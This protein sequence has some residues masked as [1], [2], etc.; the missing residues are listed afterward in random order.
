MLRLLRVTNIVSG[1]W[2]DAHLRLADVGW[3][4]D[5]VPRADENRAPNQVDGNDAE[6]QSLVHVLRQCH[7]YFIWRTFSFCRLPA[8]SPQLYPHDTA[9]LADKC[10]WSVFHL[11]D[12]RRVWPAALHSYHDST[13]VFFSAFLRVVLRKQFNTSSVDCLR[14]RFCWSFFGHVLQSSSKLIF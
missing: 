3:S 13:K 10:H 6:Q 8:A 5:I 14:C 9:V 1:I 2:R 7:R 11:H 12:D 4:D